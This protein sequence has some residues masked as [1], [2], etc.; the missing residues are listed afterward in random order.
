MQLLRYQT[1]CW[2]GMG[3]GV[4][5]AASMLGGGYYA[6]VGPNRQERCSWVA[7]L[8]FDGCGLYLCIP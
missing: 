1:A 2:T 3:R 4:A 8:S 7:A 6:L 5:A